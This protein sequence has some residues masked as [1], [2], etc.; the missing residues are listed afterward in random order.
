MTELEKAVVQEL[1]LSSASGEKL[2]PTIQRNIRTARSELIR[3]GVSPILANS[4]HTLIED[5]IICYCL[6]KMGDKDERDKYAENFRYQVDDIRKS[7]IEVP[8][9][10]ET[11]NEEEEEAGGEE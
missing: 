6:S 10:E 1:R 3:T 2:L 7:T 4:S 8:E 5:V 9:E 11:S